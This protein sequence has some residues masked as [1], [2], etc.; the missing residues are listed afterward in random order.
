LVVH[1]ASL[2]L[3]TAAV[4]AVIEAMRSTS[5]DSRKVAQAQ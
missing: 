5:D 4:S 2:K 1:P 3:K